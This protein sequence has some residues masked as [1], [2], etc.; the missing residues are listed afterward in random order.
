MQSIDLY[1]I[2]PFKCKQTFI[3]N[4]WEFGDSSLQTFSYFLLG[5]VFLGV[6][7]KLSAGVCG[8]LDSSNHISL[9]AIHRF[10]YSVETKAEPLFQATYP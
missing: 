2:S 7:G 8:G 9:E 6:H 4:I 1:S 5:E 3:N 10:S